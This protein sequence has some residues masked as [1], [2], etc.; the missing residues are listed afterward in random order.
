MND[1]ELAQA[2]IECTTEWDFSELPE[3]LQETIT[4][5]AH[6]FNEFV[7]PSPQFPALESGDAA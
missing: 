5:A 7:N 4:Q 2:F 1:T 6:A 3:V